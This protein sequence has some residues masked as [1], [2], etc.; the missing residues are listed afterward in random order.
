MAQKG[1]DESVTQSHNVLMNWGKQTNKPYSPL[2]PSGR[3]PLVWF[4]F[5]G[6]PRLPLASVRGLQELEHR[7]M[8]GFHRLFF[9]SGP[10]QVNLCVLS[11]VMNPE[12]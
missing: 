3:E 6:L 10:V 9:Q 4:L 12:L 2:E 7:E 11:E 8:K 5:V 1:C